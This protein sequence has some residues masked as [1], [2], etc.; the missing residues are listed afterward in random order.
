M[1]TFSQFLN[2]SSNIILG[3]GSKVNIKIDS[4][5]RAYGKNW[6]VKQIGGSGGNSLEIYSITDEVPKGKKNEEMW[7]PIK[8]IERLIK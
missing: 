4:I 2:E 8:S 3:D 5:I 6:K 7:I 1:K